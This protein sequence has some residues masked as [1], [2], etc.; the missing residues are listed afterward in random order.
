ML[1]ADIS[2]SGSESLNLQ[3]IYNIY[4]LYILIPWT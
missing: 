2:A 4:K 1:M 3:N